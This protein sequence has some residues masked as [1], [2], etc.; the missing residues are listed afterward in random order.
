MMSGKTRFNY[1]AKPNSIKSEDWNELK[2]HHSDEASERAATEASN[3]S[4]ESQ[5]PAA[6]ALKA[7]S[8]TLDLVPNDSGR[9]VD[10]IERFMLERRKKQNPEEIKRFKAIS[11]YRKNKRSA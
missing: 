1:P 3:D 2:R 9:L 7:E 8:K 11:A 4:D 5:T 6:E 10:F